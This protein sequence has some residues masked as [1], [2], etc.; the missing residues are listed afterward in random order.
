MHRMTVREALRGSG[1]S[2]RDA[3]LL[4][5]H[6]WDLDHAKLSFMMEEPVPEDVAARFGEL[7]EKRSIG[8]PVSKL[9]GRRAFWKDEFI[10]TLDVLDPR[11][12]TETL[13][14]EALAEPFS[15]VL[16]LGTGSGCILLSLLKEKQSAT[17]LGVDISQA[18]LDVA[19]RNA[20]ALEC[21]ARTAFQVSDWFSG[22]EGVFDLIV[23][24]PP[25]IAQDEMSALSREVAEH[26]P[27]IA[28]TP[29]G[30][31]LDAYRR[32][33]SDAGDFL[34]PGGR[35][36]VEIGPTQ[37]AEV[38]ALMA[39]SGL[40]DVTTTCDLDGRTRVVTGRKP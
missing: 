13:I 5:G 37:A 19:A 39:G 21:T 40:V 9:I 3:R 6:A 36:I 33:L 17:G 29:G 4:L 30:D 12:E 23:S 2:E 18:A 8:M 10:V 14:E 27:R 26:D 11:P 1:I 7:A 20:E 34:A 38:S 15:R 16:D 22:V 25:Y 32:I 35:L 28:L 24:N 31:G